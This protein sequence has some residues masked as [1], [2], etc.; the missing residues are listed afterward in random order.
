MGNHKQEKRARGLTHCGPTSGLT[1]IRSTPQDA[2]HVCRVFNPTINV[3][4]IAQ[5]ASLLFT[6]KHLQIEEECS[7][8]PN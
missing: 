3:P 1:S 2:Y 8:E 5:Q 7:G 4:G 6:H